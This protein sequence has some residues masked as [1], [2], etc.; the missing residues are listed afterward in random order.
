MSRYNLYNIKSVKLSDTERHPYERLCVIGEVMQHIKNDMALEKTTRR[1]KSALWRVQGQHGG[2]KGQHG[3]AKGQH[4]GAK[5]Q[6]GGA[7][8]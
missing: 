3:G 5:G 6:H 8:C 1:G 2:A 7:P 4:G